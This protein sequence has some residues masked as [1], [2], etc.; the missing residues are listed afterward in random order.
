MNNKVSLPYEVCEI[1]KVPFELPKEFH[2][3][4]KYGFF[5]NFLF[6]KYTFYYFKSIFKVSA[7]V[8]AG[9]LLFY[10]P[11][12]KVHCNIRRFKNNLKKQN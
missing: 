10:Y 1:R 3:N 9:F 6:G 11:L 2:P 7:K 4:V 8:S 12:D 5:R